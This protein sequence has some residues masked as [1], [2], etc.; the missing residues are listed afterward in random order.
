MKYL[1]SFKTFTSKDNKAYK[2]RFYDEVITLDERQINAVERR[3]KELNSETIDS[4][5]VALKNIDFDQAAIIIQTIDDILKDFND[6]QDIVDSEIIRNTEHS[7]ERVSDKQIM[8]DRDWS[9]EKVTLEIAE[10]LKRSFTVEQIRIKFSSK[11]NEDFKS[12]A[13][14][15]KGLKNGYDEAKLVVAIEKDPV[16]IPGEE[17]SIIILITV[18]TP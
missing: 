8:I 16:E 12:F 9:H 11:S 15:I 3:I 1:K 13:Y 14:T 18:L 17:E 6:Y 2:F 4:E 10:C 7:L 5:G